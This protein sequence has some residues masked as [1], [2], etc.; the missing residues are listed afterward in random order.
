MCK[1]KKK[2]AQK[3]QVKTTGSLTQRAY[4]SLRQSGNP[5][6]ETFKRNW[7]AVKKYQVRFR[8]VLRLTSDT[9]FWS[10][11]RLK[12]RN[13]AIYSLWSFLGISSVSSDKCHD[14][15]LHL[16]GSRPF[17]NLILRY[18]ET[19]HYSLRKCHDI[20]LPFNRL[21]PS[22]KCHFIRLYLNGWRYFRFFM[23][24]E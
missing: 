9:H 4:L 22:S 14:I 11:L 18:I 15:R 6:I 3:E 20:R 1:W 17:A 23:I 21:I 5:P 16:S 19:C 13:F 24:F 2:R 10:K 7:R 12:I 8:L